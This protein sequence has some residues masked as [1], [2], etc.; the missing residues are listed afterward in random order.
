MAIV[1]DERPLQPVE[2]ILAECAALAH[3]LDL[4][5]S[6]VDVVAD[7]AQMDEIVDALGAAEIVRVVD[8]GLGAEG[9]VLLE[10]LLDV[11]ALV[12]DVQAG[13]DTVGDD[14]R[15]IA[16]MRRRRPARGADGEKQA[17]AV[18]A[19]EVEVVADEALEEVAALHRVIEDVGEADLHLPQGEAVLE[20]GGAVV[21][22]QR[23]R[24]PSRP[25]VEEGL[26][27]LRAEPVADF[28]KPV[29]LAARQKTVVETLEGKPVVAHLLLGPFVA[30]E[31]ELDGIGQVAAH[32]DERGTPVPVLQVEVVVVDEGGLTGEV[33]AHAALGPAALLGAKRPHFLL[34]DADEDDPFGRVEL[35]PVLGREAVLALTSLELHHGDL[36]LVGEVVDRA[37]ESFTHRLEQR[38]RRNGVA[39]VLF[40]EVAELPRR[41]QRR[42]VAVD[43]QTIDTSNRQRDVIADNLVDVG[44]G[45]ILRGK[46]V[47]QCYSRHRG[48]RSARTGVNTSAGPGASGPWSGSRGRRPSWGPG[49]KPRSRRFEVAAPTAPATS[50]VT[51]Q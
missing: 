50:L 6:A 41:L 13:I 32:L 10:V 24:Q 11:A 20:P 40:E 42:E 34:R 36:M 49:A 19:A 30:V 46:R 4:K 47:L 16:M 23:P 5:Q 17:H 28:L 43:V 45:G 21:G 27:M 12:F 29:G 1:E 37:D 35:R 8:G 2:R 9:A 33:E 44:H 18:G 26:Q 31:A 3:A 48:R 14:A 38:R 39:E 22:R 15:A 51:P 25:A 7:G